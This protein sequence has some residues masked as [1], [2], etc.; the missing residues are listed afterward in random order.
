MDDCR[1]GWGQMEA[2]SRLLGGHK[3]HGTDGSFCIADGVGCG[4]LGQVDLVLL[5]K[6]DIRDGFWHMPI[7]EDSKKR[8]V[9]RHPGT[10][11]LIWASRLPFGYLEAPRLFC[12]LT[13]A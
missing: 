11:K 10:G 4:A 1:P 7:A 6:Y 5:A 12:G 2:V 13:E 3:P 8:L 9:V